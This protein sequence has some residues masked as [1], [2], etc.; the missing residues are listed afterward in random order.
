MRIGG[1]VL[2]QL[3]IVSAV[4]AANRD[5]SGP[6]AQSVDIFHCDFGETVDANYDLWPDG[7]TRMRGPGYPQY[8]KI[9]IVEKP[10]GPG[11]KDHEHC[12]RI[13]LDG[14]AALVSTPPAPVAPRFS[15]VAEVNARTNGLKHDIASLT[16]TFLDE[17]RQVLEEIESP[18]LNGT[19]PWTSLKI[20]PVAPSSEKTRFAV[21]TFHVRPHEKEDLRG[22]VWLGDVRLARLPRMTL[23]AGGL[24]HLYFTG[25]PI[26]VTTDITG[27]SAHDNQVMFELFDAYGKSLAQQKQALQAESAGG[28]SSDAKVSSSARA[29][30]RP[31]VPGPGFYR[32]DVSMVGD[33]GL[34][35]HRSI[36]LAVIQ[37]Q[38]LAKR[39]EFGWA[40]PNGEQPLDFGPLTTVL[41]QAGISW[42]KFP[43][44]YDGNDSA[45]ADRLAWFAE[46][47]GQSGIEM[48]GLLD[49]PPPSQAKLFGSTERLPI[50]LIFTD[51]AIWQPAIEPLMMRLS[52]KVHWWQ[53][54]GDD[55]ISYV[56]LP[57]LVAKVGEVKQA[58]DRYGQETKLALVW[59]TVKPPPKAENAPWA[60]L[61]YSAVSTM[62]DETQATELSAEQIVKQFGDSSSEPGHKWLSLN[63]LPQT[64]ND[65]TTRIS[66]LLRRM[67]AA[68]ASGINAS[69]VPRPFDDEVGL[70]HSDGTPAELFLPWRTTAL[71]ISGREHLGTLRLP[72]GS[73]NHVFADADEAVMVLWNERT[74][75]EHAFLGEQA[76]RVDLW[77]R[78]T[79]LPV[80]TNDGLRQQVIEVGPEPIILRG[81]N[82]SIVR[83][84]LAF[85][86]AQPTLESVFGKEQ[87]V[88]YKFRNTFDKTVSGE[89]A[90][91]APALCDVAPTPQ[92]FHLT[93]GEEKQD[94]FSLPLKSDADSGPQKVRIDFTVMTNDE[95]RFSVYRTLTVGLDDITVEL[96][97]ELEESG[98]LLVKAHVTNRTGKPVVFR[99]TVFAPDR[100]RQQVL[101]AVPAP[102]RTTAVYRLPDGRSLLGKDLRLRLEEMGGSRVL[103][104]H[105]KAQE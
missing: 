68:K 16:L 98:E 84:C 58:F 24:Q 49:Q 34:S 59:Q 33:D 79:P 93:A 65:T 7:W 63:P 100:R 90:I 61:S 81:L 62:A 103:N 56:G 35:L 85:E 77:G 50:A 94:S 23:R 54:G 41:T 52:L 2:L 27:M 75:R 11:I 91:T 51:R 32:V 21:L 76:R 38:S 67:I 78:E 70:F 20:G 64:G 22:E 96:D 72:R 48:V 9:G 87:P 15:Y 83:W 18:R 1:A 45:R 40:L 39:G 101:M 31:P 60:G 55:D 26:Q 3:I 8:L 97:S 19:M 73:T 47:L 99:A 82:A 92:R 86:F 17:Q 89:L 102:D 105:V 6:R 25:E 37:A 71:A 80:E 57:D 88:T 104:N 12:L 66:D 44:W 95:F 13:K 10:A 4:F 69:F 53:L 28:A 29:T 36:T 74:V 30:W 43:A 14:G 42:V 46:R 5:D